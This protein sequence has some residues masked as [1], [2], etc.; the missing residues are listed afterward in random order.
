M[1]SAPTFGC[2]LRGI[3]HVLINPPCR[4][5]PQKRT[6]PDH[7]RMSVL[8]HKRTHAVQQKSDVECTA[9]RQGPRFGL[10]S[11]PQPPNARGAANF[12]TNDQAQI[13]LGFFRSLAVGKCRI[14]K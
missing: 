2:R 5:H 4:L 8:G 11:R 10:G 7:H 3:R 6:S 13:A 12:L 14:T 9:P 1:L